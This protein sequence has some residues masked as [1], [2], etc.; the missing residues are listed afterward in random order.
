MTKV[1]LD[2]YEKQQH[3]IFNDK[4]RERIFAND[5]INVLNVN[6][7]NIFEGCQVM[8][9][10]RNIVPHI[11]SENCR[12]EAYRYTGVMAVYLNNK[13]CTIVTFTRNRACKYMMRLREAKELELFSK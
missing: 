2:V 7:R 8:R 12:S 6:G 5:I 9:N 13:R 4:E 10:D 1:L 11:D 3:Q